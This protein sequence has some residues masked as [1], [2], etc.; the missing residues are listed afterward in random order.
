MHLSDAQLDR[1]F[2]Q[3]L[4]VKPEEVAFY[5]R[6]HPATI[7]RKIRQMRIHPINLSRYRPIYRLTREQV[8]NLAKL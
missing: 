5:L 6:L 7:R 1:L 8:R 3:Y 4:V 2:R